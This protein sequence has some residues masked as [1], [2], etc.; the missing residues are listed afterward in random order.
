RIVA[1]MWD[2]IKEKNRFAT[3][4]KIIIYLLFCLFLIE[5]LPILDIEGS[6]L[7][8]EKR[9][10]DEDK[11]FYNQVVSVTQEGDMIYMLPY[12]DYPEDG[13]HKQLTGY[14]LT[15]TG[16][17]WSYGGT[18]DREAAMFNR[19]LS[20]ME[21]EEMIESMRKAGYKGICIDKE[22]YEREEVDVLIKQISN[23]LGTMPIES[24]HDAF[25]KL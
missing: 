14:L 23:I 2:K 25:F 4:S 24:E 17:K 9:L 19:K 22:G 1:M 7:L 6:H 10:Y 5:E 12:R 18:R 20:E 13:G 8:E 15:D 3:V 21:I 11:M 16:L